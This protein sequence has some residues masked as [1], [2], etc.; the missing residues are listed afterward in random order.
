MDGG[1]VHL[2]ATGDNGQP[3]RICL[4]WSI[5]AQRTSTTCLTINDTKLQPG[6][7]DEA[8]WI[9]LLR[10]A[11]IARPNRTSEVPSPPANRLVM[12]PDAK[13][14]LDAIDKGPHA[15]LAALRD[16]LLQKLQSPVHKWEVNAST[17]TRRQGQ[18]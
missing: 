13:A 2:Q 6:S 1:S 14:Y 5:N 4:D 3:L 10:N 7:A 15:A 11:E 8:E 12:A 18:L 16:S 9:N 17:K